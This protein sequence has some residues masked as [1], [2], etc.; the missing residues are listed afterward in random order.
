MNRSDII[1][2]ISELYPKLSRKEVEAIVKELFATMASS[3]ATGKRIEIRGFGCFSLKH[4][5][6][7]KVRNPRH[8]VAIDSGE[9][10]VVYFRAGKELRERVDVFSR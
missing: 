3:I 5:A 9:R 1:K 7:G 2:R 8:G 6:A 10:H 4:R